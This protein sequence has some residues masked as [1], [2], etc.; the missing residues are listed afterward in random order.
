MSDFVFVS[1]KLSDV[2]QMVTMVADEVQ[3]GIIL[4][5]SEDEIAQ[6]I[7]SYIVIKKDDEMLGYGALHI[8]S[9]KLAEIRSLIVKDGFRGNKLGFRLVDKL[10]ENAKELSLQEVFVLTYKKSFFERLGFIEIQKSELPN[11]KIWADCINC[12]LFP[13]CDEIA[14]ILKI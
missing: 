1:P 4:P 11:Q 8:Y 7:R 5:R 13:V 6:N 14:L 3:K 10:I 9:D 12:K 2:T